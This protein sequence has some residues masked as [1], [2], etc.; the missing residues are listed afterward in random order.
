MLISFIRFHLTSF[1]AFSFLFKVTTDR[2]Y[3]LVQSFPIT[4]PQL[5]QACQVKDQNTLMTLNKIISI[6]IYFHIIFMFVLNC[7]N[8][9]LLLVALPLSLSV[10]IFVQFVILFVLCSTFCK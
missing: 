7:T 6:L 5:Y 10:L 4:V 3:P 1:P 9:Q 8:Y 2:F